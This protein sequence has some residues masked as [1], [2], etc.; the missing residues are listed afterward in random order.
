MDKGL[1]VEALGKLGVDKKRNFSQSYDLIVNLKDLDLKKNENQVDFFAQLPNGTGRPVGICAFVDT[2]MAEE[3][4]AVFDAVILADDFPKYKDKKVSRKLAR[5][6]DFF[7]AQANLMP[8][9][10]TFFGRTLG[11]KG[12]MPNPKAGAIIAPKANL[13][14]LK[15]NLQ[16]TIR[17]SARTA[18]MVQCI[19]GTEKMGADKSA[20]N[21]VNVYEQIVH[22]LPN[23]EANVKSVLVKLTMSS[24]VR[25]K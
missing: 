3:A 16:R 6:F 10:A 5:K 20:E 1:V 9:V 24:P 21:L 17:V 19:V 14:Q 25:L 15:E 4:R 7:V 23:E 22:H 13:R 12:K 2:Q 8:Q 18:P 11:P